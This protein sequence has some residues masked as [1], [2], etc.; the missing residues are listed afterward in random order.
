MK[1]KWTTRAKTDFSKV[2]EY[3]NENWG[4]REVENFINQTDIVLKGI[5]KNPQMFVESTKKNSVYKGFITKHNS[6]F[7]RVKPQKKEILL[8][9]FWDNRQNQ[10]KR[11]Y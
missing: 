6:L 5:A 10:K 11:K 1:I 9:T 3:L 2:L 7:Y 4:I 8:L